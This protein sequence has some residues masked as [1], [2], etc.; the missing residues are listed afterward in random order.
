MT[1]NRR[2][3]IALFLSTALGTIAVQSQAAGANGKAAPQISAGRV[4]QVNALAEKLIK[5]DD[6]AKKEFDRLHPGVLPELKLQLPGPGAAEFD[7][8]NLNKVGEARR[9]LTGDCWA[10]AATEALECNYLIRNNRRVSLSSQPL[11]DYL[12]LG[13]FTDKEM[14]DKTA[15]ASDF[16]L[17]IGTATLAAYPYTGE[18]ANPRNTALPYRAIAWGYVQHDDKRPTDAQLKNALLRHGPLVVDVR[19]TPKFKAYR[20][21]LYEETITPDMKDKT[22]WHA[23]LLVGW[24]D[25]RGANG[26]WKIKNTWGTTWGVQGYMWIGRGSNELGRNAVWLRAASTYYGPGKAFADLVAE[27]R[28]LPS[29]HGALPTNVPL[30]GVMFAGGTMTTTD[31]I[32]PISLTNT[33]GT[34]SAEKLK[35]AVPQGGP[36]DLLRFI[37]KL[38]AETSPS[39]AQANINIFDKRKGRAILEASDR[40]LTSNTTTPNIR[41]AF[42][43]K[44][45]AVKLL[46]RKRDPQVDDRL[47]SLPTELERAGQGGLMRFLRCVLVGEKLRRAGRVNSKTAHEYLADISGAIKDNG[48]D[49]TAAFVANEAAR[50]VLNAGDKKGAIAAFDDLAEQ[51]AASKNKDVAKEASFFRKAAEKIRRGNELRKETQVAEYK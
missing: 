6:D 43:Y 36:E 34:M 13:G 8:C 44:I 27:A 12:K 30:Q 40:I 9:Q 48:L 35:F 3:A 28:P 16:F 50:A 37:R 22:G 51:C 39:K 25:S 38:G 7:W 42:T 4:A 18:P 31:G 46:Y 5:L 11:L 33:S 15:R 23:V 17:K 41:S 49:V 24:D 2:I 10:N 19:V 26:A 47:D 32:V 21:G 29:V 1:T 45:A 20:G 14:A